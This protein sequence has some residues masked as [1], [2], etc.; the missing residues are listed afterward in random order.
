MAMTIAE[1]FGIE[2]RVEDCRKEVQA[3]EVALERSP[4]K[5]E[6]IR[7]DGERRIY[8]CRSSQKKVAIKEI[9][10]FVKSIEEATGEKVAWR[11][12][13]EKVFHFSQQTFNEVSSKTSIKGKMKKF[14]NA[15]FDLED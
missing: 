14:L 5:A 9:L 15:F 6:I 7:K 3:K 1:F 12:K 2:D 4:Y 8:P 13:G 10:L 11:F